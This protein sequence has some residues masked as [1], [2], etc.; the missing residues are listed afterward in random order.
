MAGALLVTLLVIVA[1]VAVRA[2]MRDNQPTEREPVDYLGAVDGAQGSGLTVVYPPRLPA[3]WRATSVDLRPSDPPR[4]SLGLLTDEDR[5]V[6]VQQ[7]DDDLGDLLAT[8]VDGD[9]SEGE[10]VAIDS[11]VASRWRSFSD[12]GGDH[13]YA[14]EVGGLGWVLV[15]G[16]VDAPVLRDIVAEL[17]TTLRQG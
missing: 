9:A 17:V 16:S 10:T 15:Y 3:G 5:F 6:G 13:A 4:W 8:Y 14:A 2:L 7:E 11:A 12:E 1:F